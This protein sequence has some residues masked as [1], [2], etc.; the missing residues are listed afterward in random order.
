MR[1]QE[2]LQTLRVSDVMNRR[3]V[4]VQAEQSMAEAAQLLLQKE[5]SGAPVVDAE[6]RC[7]GI[8]SATDFMRRESHLARRAQRRPGGTGNDQVALREPAEADQVRAYMTAAVQT[9]SPQQFLVQA[10]RMMC[11]EHVHRL[12]VLDAQGRPVG[13]ITALDIVAGVT[14]AADEAAGG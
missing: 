10:A 9:A 3:V 12:P 7:V 14:Q 5:V 4:T 13:I 11:A 1:I 8:L 2:R 6:G